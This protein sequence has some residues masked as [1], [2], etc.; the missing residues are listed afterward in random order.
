MVAATVQS[1]D[2]GTGRLKLQTS[3]GTVVEFK[4]PEGVASDLQQG[5]RVQVV[6]RKQ[7]Q[8]GQSEQDASKMKQS[9]PDPSGSQQKQ[10]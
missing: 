8:A 2:E 7:E 3:N 6:I 9:Q 10:Q 1:L 4:A 5:D